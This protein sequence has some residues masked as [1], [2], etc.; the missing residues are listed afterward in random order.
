MRE[1]LDAVKG[2]KKPMRILLLVTFFNWIALF[3]FFEYNTDWMGVEVYG[4]KDKEQSLYQMGVRNG[5]FGM[6]LNS[7]ISGS[8]SL[9]INALVRGFRG[10]KRLWGLVNI[11]LS[12]CLAMTVPISMMAKHLRQFAM[13]P[14]GALEPLPPPRGV[15]AAALTLYDV[16]GIPLAITYRIPFALASIFSN[17]AGAGQGLSLAILNLSVVVP[18]MLMS[19]ISGPLDNMFGGSNLPSFVVGSLAAAI[20]GMLSIILLPSPPSDVHTTITGG[21]SH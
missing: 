21:G 8:V 4:G 12:V 20:S 17:N 2:L 15:K 3:P 18:Q 6:T 11:L 13:G 19:A 9:G 16:L 1:F 5:G 10:E 14:S 7:L